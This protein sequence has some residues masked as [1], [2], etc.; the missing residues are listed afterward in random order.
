M[1]CPGRSRMRAS[2]AAG[3]MNA[4]FDRRSISNDDDCRRRGH[5]S[6]PPPN[7]G[8]E[9]SRLLRYCHGSFF[10]I[11]KQRNLDRTTRHTA[12]PHRGSPKWDVGVGDGRAETDPRATIES[13][14]VRDVTRIARSRFRPCIC[15]PPHRRIRV[16]LPWFST[17]IALSGTRASAHIVATAPSLVVSPPPCL[18]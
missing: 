6:P 5:V 11:M 13:Q 2:R 1:S 7:T 14:H 9:D 12:R 8:L 10:V 16:S 15:R 3:S 4:S 17:R 18:R